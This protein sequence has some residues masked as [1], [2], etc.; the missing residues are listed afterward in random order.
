MSREIAAVDG[1]AME[2]ERSVLSPR[3]EVNVTPV[4]GCRR[5]LVGKK[6]ATLIHTRDGDQWSW[7]ARGMK[8]S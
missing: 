6:R 8:R 3:R 5:P 2:T 4:F 7:S 1:H